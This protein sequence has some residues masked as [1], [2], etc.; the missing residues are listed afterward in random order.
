MRE[1]KVLING[2]EVNFKIGGEREPLLI[3]HGWGGSSDSW[4]R[5]QEIL[6]NKGYKVICP[7][8][9]GFGKS[10]TPISPWN[11]DNYVDWLKDFIN[12]LNLENFFLLAHSFGGR[13]AIRFATLY[14]EKIKSLIL[15]ASA[16]IK[17]KPRPH[18][19][20]FRVLAKIGNALFSRKPFIRFQNGARNYFY[21][22]LRQRDYLRAD[23]T[24]KKTIKKVLGEDL[25]SDLPKIKT[26]TL[27]IW[28]QD[29]K[30]VPLKY[31]YIF[32]E[33]IKNSELEILPK[34]GHSPH[35]EV[36]EKLSEI[37]THFLR[38]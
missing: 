4:I 16:G 20:I 32:K 18:Q 6:A 31:A 7:D 37:I 29:D 5:V 17:P 24:M 3:L 9:P 21:M 14:P 27:I 36:P 10:K 19:K 26:K 12:L 2:L 34:I 28:G 35:L 11:V 1:E 30:M 8:F 22:L 38:S 15:C 23:G 25:L 13:V 33:K